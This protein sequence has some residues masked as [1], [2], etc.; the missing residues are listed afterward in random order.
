[1]ADKTQRSF[2]KDYLDKR[3]ESMEQFLDTVVESEMLRSSPHLLGFLQCGEESEWQK[4]KEELDKSLKNTSNLQETFDRKH[5]EGKNGL[6][7]EDF[8]TL[9]PELQC[10]ITGSLKDYAIELDELLKMSEPLYEKLLDG[11]KQLSTDI[12]GLSTT[13]TK[14]AEVS[15]EL[16]N[17]HKKFNGAVR[18]HKWDRMQDMFGALNQHVVTWEK[19]IQK[20]VHTMQS[21]LLK[22]LDLTLGESES[23]QN[24]LG[25]HLGSK[26]SKHCGSRVFQVLGRSGKQKRK[27]VCPGESQGL[28]N[29][30]YKYKACPGGYSQK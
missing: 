17:L 24:V 22:A 20:Q 2:E 5:F 16:Y 30:L 29:R 27:A 18:S 6:R 13:L 15:G 3:A 12:L 9:Q 11:T 28:G 26:P 10:R 21:P 14:I 25:S 8:E 7:V 19:S 23:F 1:M 4:L